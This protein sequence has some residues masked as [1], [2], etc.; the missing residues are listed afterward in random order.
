MILLVEFAFKA[1]HLS[2]L[3]KFN[4]SH[5]SSG[6]NKISSVVGTEASF[7]LLFLIL[8]LSNSFENSYLTYP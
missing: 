7:K 5:F 3:S 1:I 6:Y 8:I 4:V 2:E